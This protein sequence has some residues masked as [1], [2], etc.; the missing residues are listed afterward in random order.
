MIENDEIITPKEAGMILKLRSETVRE[1]M[2]KGVIP[3]CKLG[4]SWRTTKGAIYGCMENKMGLE[5]PIHLQRG[6]NN[7]QGVLQIQKRGKRLD[8]KKKNR[9]SGFDEIFFPR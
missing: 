3:A 8:K 7:P 9:T 4:G 6:K 5:S 1:L 2:R